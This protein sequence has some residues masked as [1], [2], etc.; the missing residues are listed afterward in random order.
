MKTKYR[1][2]LEWVKQQIEDAQLNTGD[3]LP[4]IRLLTEQYQCS[5]SQIIYPSINSFFGNLGC[6]VSIDICFYHCHYF[7]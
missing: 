3:K 6:S 7:C 5:N 1:G 4:S 2:I